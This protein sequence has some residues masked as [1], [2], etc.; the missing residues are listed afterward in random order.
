MKVLVYGSVN[1]DRVFQVDHIALPGETVR[2]LSLGLFAGGKGANQAVALARAGSEVWFCGKSGDDAAWIIEQMEASGVRTGLLRRVPEPNG[3]TVIQ[4][5]RAGQNTIITYPG[6]NGAIT[7]AEIDEALASFGAGDCLV[8]QNEIPFVG[9]LIERATEKGMYTV[10]NPSPITPSVLSLPLGK[11]GLLVVNEIEG[12]ALAGL[13]ADK[14]YERILAALLGRY[15]ETEI[16]MTLGAK[17]AC[18]AHKKDF[19]FASGAIVKAVDT[20]GAGDTFLGYF[21][22]YKNEGRSIENCLAD[23]CLAAAVAVTRP[24]AMDSIPFRKEVDG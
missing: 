18:Y 15:P 11:V 14:G 12:A 8:L 2:S 23:A 6:A 9:Y 19:Y 24:G 13:E 16:V 5:D 7:E 17:G 4:V 1:I 21:L 3:Q 20:T 22:T 10:L